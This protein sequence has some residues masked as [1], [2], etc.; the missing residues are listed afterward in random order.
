[1]AVPGLEETAGDLVLMGTEVQM[2][3]LTGV[4]GIEGDEYIA[5]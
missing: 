3:R 1:M 5:V 2:C 4:L